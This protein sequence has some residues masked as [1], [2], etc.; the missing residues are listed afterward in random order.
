MS[1][2]QLARGRKLTFSFSLQPRCFCSCREGG[3]GEETPE[4]FKER[5]GSKKP[6]LIFDGSELKRP[7]SESC[8]CPSPHPVPKGKTHLRSSHPREGVC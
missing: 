6:C 2:L 5:G 8:G 7:P 3:G 1:Y 4:I